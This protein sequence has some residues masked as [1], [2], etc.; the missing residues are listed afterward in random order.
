MLQL[1]LAILCSV[2]VG[3]LIKYARMKGI[4][5]AQSIAVNYIITTTLTYFLLKPDFKGESLTDIVIHH[6]AAYIFLILS[7][8]LPIV[9]LV[10]AKS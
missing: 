10:Q 7:L 4:H 6:P 9:F 8:S 3:V 1:V 2:T 5:I